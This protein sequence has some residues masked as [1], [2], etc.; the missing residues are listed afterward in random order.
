MSYF[1]VRISQIPIGWTEEPKDHPN[2]GEIRPVVTY[3]YSLAQWQTMFRKLGSGEDWCR[4]EF[5]DNGKDGDGI[6]L[7]IHAGDKQYPIVET[8]LPD[9]SLG[10]IIEALTAIRNLRKTE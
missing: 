7:R 6:K 2:L 9:E 1:D 10:T 4:L 8:L 5:E 3:Q